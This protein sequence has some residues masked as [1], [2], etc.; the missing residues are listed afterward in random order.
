MQ[1]YHTRKFLQQT[2]ILKNTLYIALT[3]YKVNSKV[4]QMSICHIE[5]K[6]VHTKQ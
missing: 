3:K 2:K 5:T 4:L 1:T 6:I